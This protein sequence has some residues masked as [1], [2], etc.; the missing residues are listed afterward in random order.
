MENKFISRDA[1]RK[2]KAREN[3]TPNQCETRLA[4]QRE[5]RQ[6]KKAREDAEEREAR[7]ARDKERKRV[8]LAAETNEQRE[9]RLSYYCERR[10]YLKNIQNTTDQDLNSQRQ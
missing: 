4:K 1:L 10:N 3:E 5:S 8:K 6:Q 2:R 9:K 7:V